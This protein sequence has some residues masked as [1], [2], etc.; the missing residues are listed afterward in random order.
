MGVIGSH[1]GVIFLSDHFWGA[2]MRGTPNFFSKFL[3][4]SFVN[5]YIGKVKKIWV[6]FVRSCNCYKHFKMPRALW[7]PPPCLIGGAI[8][9]KW[10]CASVCDIKICYSNMF[11]IHQNWLYYNQGAWHPVQ[12]NIP[13]HLPDLFALPGQYSKFLPMSHTDVF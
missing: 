10:Y 8:S 1:G 13:G 9:W 4:K 7:T 2:K 6:T 11:K 12:K 5:R 3:V